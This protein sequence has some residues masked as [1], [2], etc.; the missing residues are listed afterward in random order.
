VIYFAIGEVT[1]LMKNIET[2]D[3]KRVFAIFAQTMP[4][5][6]LMQVDDA[7]Q[8]EKLTKELAAFFGLFNSRSREFFVYDAVQSPLIFF[9]IRNRRHFISFVYDV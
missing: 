4:C 6:T 2:L 1:A 7:L 3:Q 5:Q 8:V 9:Y